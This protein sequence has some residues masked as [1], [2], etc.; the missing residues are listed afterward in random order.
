MESFRKALVVIVWRS[1]P[2]AADAKVLIL[3]LLGKRGGF[4]QTVTGGVEKAESFAE[5]A[6]RE[7]QEETGLQFDREPQYLG[8]EQTFESRHGGESHEKAFYLP[9]FGGASPPEPR[10]DGKEHD[11]F[12]WV[13]PSAG[14][15][16]VR[17]PFNARAIE[18]ASVGLPPLLLSRRGLFYQDGEEI[19][20]ARTAALFHRSL[21]REKDGLFVV[22]CAEESLDVILED[23]PRYVLSYDSG[24]LK[25]SGGV[26]EKLNPESL[27]V[28]AD[29][30]LICTLANGWQA[31]FLTAAY[32]EIAKDIRELSAGQYVL[33][34]L[35]RDHELRVAK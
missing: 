8:L 11:E 14:A 2:G 13:T 22:R 19:T 26:E 34:F 10:L 33:H 12:A 5:G 21:A 20:H 1:Q 29:N 15:A 23:S 18:R 3:K 27:R 4:W 24:S 28:R 35:G 7:A 17:F 6:L 31:T 30:S 16:Q 9:V 32:Y 25:L